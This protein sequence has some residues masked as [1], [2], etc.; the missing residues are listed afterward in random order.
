MKRSVIV[1]V[2]LASLFLL[3]V[4]TFAAERQGAVSFSPFVG[5]Y[6]FDGI[7]HARTRPVYGARLGLNATP[8]WQFEGVFDFVSS[9]NNQSREDFR[10][11][12]YHLDV[13][14]N[15]QPNHALVLYLVVG[16]GAVT[17]EGEADNENTDATFHA[18]L[19]FKYYVTKSVA[20]RADARHVLVFEGTDDN[21]LSNWEYSLGLTFLFGG[22][23]PAMTAQP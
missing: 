18:G 21:N 19:G 14:Y 15:F 11:Y 20:L 1:P 22:V 7:Q 2:L 13:L 4:P 9:E 10:A 12:S 8:S 17:F 6:T 3:V 23:S 5:G 16:G